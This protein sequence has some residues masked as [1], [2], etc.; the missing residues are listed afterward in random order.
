[1]SDKLGKPLSGQVINVTCKMAT[2]QQRWFDSNGILPVEKKDSPACLRGDILLSSVPINSSQAREP[3]NAQGPVFNLDTLAMFEEQ[4]KKIPLPPNN[5]IQVVVVQNYAQYLADLYDARTSFELYLATHQLCFIIL[6]SD[7]AFDVYSP[8]HRIFKGNATN[9][10]KFE[11]IDDVYALRQNIVLCIPTTMDGSFRAEFDAKV[12]SQNLNVIIVEYVEN[13]DFAIDN[14]SE[15]AWTFI[16][17]HMTPAQVRTAS[18]SKQ[19]IAPRLPVY[20]GVALTDAFFSSAYGDDRVTTNRYSLL[21]MRNGPVN[22]VNEDKLHWIFRCE[23]YNYTSD[24]CRIS[25]PLWFTTPHTLM[26]TSYE[27]AKNDPLNV[28]NKLRRND[29]EGSDVATKFFVIPL[30]TIS[31]T[32]FAFY[33]TGYLDETNNGRIVGIAKQNG[34]PGYNIDVI[35]IGRGVV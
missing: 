2:E 6:H 17:E 10:P 34:D 31:T 23:K 33:T 1:M 4:E 29:K 16:K 21:S 11:V 12:K 32:S 35:N 22:V 7:G 9:Y 28:N 18:N 26:R 15:E 19:R 5:D 8:D 14:M 27:S 20:M 25:R 30:K 3:T 24:G 13:S